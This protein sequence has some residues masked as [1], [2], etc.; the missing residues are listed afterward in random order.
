M[1]KKDQEE[2]YLPKEGQ[3]VNLFVT[4]HELRSDQIDFD[5]RVDFSLQVS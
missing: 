2:K 4:N 3:R 1:S 5:R